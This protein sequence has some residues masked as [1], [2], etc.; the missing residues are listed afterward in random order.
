MGVNHAIKYYYKIATI[1]MIF[2][3]MKGDTELFLF[4]VTHSPNISCC[5]NLCHMSLVNQNGQQQF[6][7]NL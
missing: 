1:R 2:L 4:V 7:S 5:I 6:K 3:V